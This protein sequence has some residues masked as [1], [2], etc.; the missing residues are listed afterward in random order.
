MESASSLR[1]GHVPFYRIPI[2]NARSTYVSLPAFSQDALSSVFVRFS[3]EEFG[4]SC[5][6]QGQS[7]LPMENLFQV[8]DSRISQ[9]K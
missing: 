1:D 3:Q 6:T 5:D 9:C 8:F 7:F 4:V 2:L